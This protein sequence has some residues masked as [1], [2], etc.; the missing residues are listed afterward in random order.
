MT[1][2]SQTVLLSTA[3]TIAFVHTVIGVDHSLPFVVLGRARS[4]SLSRVLA[5]TALCGAGHVGS[6]VLLGVAGMWLGT[7][8][9]HLSWL[10]SLRGG[11]AAWLLIAFGTIYALHALWARRP[12]RHLH[13]H[14]DGEIHSHT[15]DHRQH[16]HHTHVTQADHSNVFWSLFLI[17]VLGPCEPL[18]PLLMA[19]AS[20]SAWSTCVAVIAV[21]GG[22]TLATMLG[23]VAAGWYGAQ[24][25]HLQRLS[26]H[27][28][29][30]AGVAIGV[31]GV[32][33]KVFEI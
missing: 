9:E 1:P 29:V 22:V 23:V 16:A 33:V 8:L 15:H 14:R 25:V 17:F 10:Q 31:S 24:Q 2:Q 28:D 21:F 18:I 27:A 7:S 13:V 19:P 5:I 32:L 20:Q 3:A 4:W 11:L 12:H 30:F 6:S 26:A